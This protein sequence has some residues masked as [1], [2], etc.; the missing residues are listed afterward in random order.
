M[1]EY[2]PG[3]WVQHPNDPGLVWTQWTDDKGGEHSAYVATVFGDDDTEGESAANVCLIAAAPEL[4]A[5]GIVAVVNCGCGLPKPSDLD[6]LLRYVAMDPAG[7]SQMCQGCLGLLR[8][9]AKVEGR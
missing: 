2:T 6:G 1:S 8:V 5:A 4:L 7:A 3:N 9:I